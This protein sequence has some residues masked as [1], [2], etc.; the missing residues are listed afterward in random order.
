MYKI[1]SSGEEASV[2]HRF[3]ANTVR[4]F[5]YNTARP[6]GIKGIGSLGFLPSHGV[7]IDAANSLSSAW[8]TIGMFGLRGDAALARTLHEPDMM[9]LS[10][11]HAREI[12]PEETEALLD[13]L[14]SPLTAA[15]CL[16]AALRKTPG[17]AAALNRMHQQAAEASA[18]LAERLAEIE[19]MHRRQL[20]ELW[21]H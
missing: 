1:H 18:K 10:F 3:G 8:Q 5:R 15:H 21:L 9:G 7:Q 14:T 2:T 19:A 11:T 6:S 17:E 12:D 4:F 20:P 16:A 13:Y